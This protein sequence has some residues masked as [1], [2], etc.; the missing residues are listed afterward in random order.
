[1]NCTDEQIAAIHQAV[2]DLAHK[3]IEV[4]R[5]LIDVIA[6]LI[7]AIDEIIGKIIELPPRQRYKFVKRLGVENN[8]IFFRRKKAYHCRNNC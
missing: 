5:P 4:V 8:P 6:E 7:D 1:M 2:Q 3:L